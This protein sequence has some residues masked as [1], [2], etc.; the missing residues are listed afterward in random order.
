MKADVLKAI[1]TANELLC[2][3][4]RLSTVFDIERMDF[5]GKTILFD[6]IQNYAALTGIPIN[7]LL[8]DKCS[9]LRDG[10]KI[11]RPET[12]LYLILHNGDMA[13][14]ERIRWTRAH[15]LGHIFLKHSKDGD[16]EEL[17]A[18]M[19]AAQLLMP[20]FTI[21]MMGNIVRPSAD[22][23]ASTFGVSLSAANRRIMDIYHLAA[24]LTEHDKRIFAQ[25]R[26]YLRHE[27]IK[28]V[29]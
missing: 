18:N 26:K 25:Q 2:A 19:F 7:I 1:Q 13:M 12:D 21:K 16:I 4:R 17:E 28:A 14:D 22:F 24:P 27:P 20:W 15:E 10:I 23:I 6:S 29:G 11:H 3:Q 9:P 5:C 8:H